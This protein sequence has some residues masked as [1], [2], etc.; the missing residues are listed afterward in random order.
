V[1]IRIGPP[2]VG[3]VVGIF[4]DF[5]LSAAFNRNVSGVF[6]LSTAAGEANLLLLA[7]AFAIALPIRSETAAARGNVVDSAGRSPAVRIQVRGVSVLDDNRA[8]LRTGSEQGPPV[9][10][11]DAAGSISGSNFLR[12]IPG[13][14]S[15][16]ALDVAVGNG[17][18]TILGNICAGGQIRL[19]GAPLAAPW[20]PLNAITF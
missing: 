6:N 10:D 11:I 8:S 13:P 5:L 15:A 4:T 9:A 16:I 12:R 3:F 19:N 20:I 17:P 1:G 7:P 14:D 18:A 2:V